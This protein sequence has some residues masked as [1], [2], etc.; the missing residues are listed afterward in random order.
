MMA[1]SGDNRLSKTCEEFE[2]LHE[3][4]DEVALVERLFRE[5]REVAHEIG[6]GAQAKK[7]MDIFGVDPPAEK[8]VG[9]AQDN[10]AKMFMANQGS[11]GE[12]A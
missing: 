2:R 3:A 7:L 1:A 5:A 4:G 10:L 12:G 11:G 6:P 8:V 9:D